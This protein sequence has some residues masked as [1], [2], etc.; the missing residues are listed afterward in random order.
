MVN[1]PINPDKIFTIVFDAVKPGNT[2]NVI[3]AKTPNPTKIGVAVFFENT[4]L[5]NS[6]I[7]FGFVSKGWLG[8]KFRLKNHNR[9]LKFDE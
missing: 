5:N 4:L 3:I 8:S 1:N 9:V 2:M 7:M 6:F